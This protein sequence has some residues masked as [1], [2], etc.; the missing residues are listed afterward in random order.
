MSL[1]LE[2]K[3]KIYTWLTELSVAAPLERHALLEQ[4]IDPKTVWQVSHPINTLYGTSAILEQFF[5]P[6]HM[7][8][9]FGTPDGHPLFSR[10]N[11]P[12]VFA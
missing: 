4:R 10:G 7:E 1:H 3:Q 5:E 2:N 12:T 11:N 8:T 9:A 6:L